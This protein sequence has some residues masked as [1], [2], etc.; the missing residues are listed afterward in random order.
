MCLNTKSKDQLLHFNSFELVNIFLR[1]V[2]FKFFLLAVK[3]IEFSSKFPAGVPCF[4]PSFFLSH[5]KTNLIK[6]VGVLEKVS[7]LRIRIK[8]ISSLI[9]VVEAAAVAGPVVPYRLPFHFTLTIYK[10]Q[11]TVKL[12]VKADGDIF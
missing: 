10:D 2:F 1:G 3:Q 11:N 6:V 12:S 9:K 4:F 5:I 8:K 7:L